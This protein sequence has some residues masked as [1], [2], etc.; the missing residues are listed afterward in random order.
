MLAAAF[1]LTLWIN[2]HHNDTYRHPPA[3][4]I[5][6]TPRKSFNRCDLPVTAAY[7]AGLD[8][9]RHLGRCFIEQCQGRQ[10]HRPHC[11]G[12]EPPAKT[13]VL[14]QNQMKF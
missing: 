4:V 10:A 5:L 1:I 9:R 11:K 2:Y 3:L 8:T 14:L 6:Y 13:I 12:H 7:L